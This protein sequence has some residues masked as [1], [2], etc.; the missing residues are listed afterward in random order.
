MKIVLLMG[1]FQSLTTVKLK[2]QAEFGKQTPNLNCIKDV[3]QRFTETG[4]VED[5]KRSGRP[6]VITEE[7]VEEVRDV[8][9]AERRQNVRTVAAVCAIPKDTVHRT[10][11][12]HLLLQPYKGHFVQQLYEEAFQDRVDMCE[13]LEPMLLN[14]HNEENF[15]FSDEAAFH[16]NVLINK[17]NVRYWYETNPNI[18]PE[19]V[20]KSP[21]VN[22]VQQ[23]VNR[24]EDDTVDGPKYRFHVSRIFHSRSEKE[25]KDAL[26]RISAG[27]SSSSFCS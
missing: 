5:R 20:M 6:S 25:E 13:T 16:L 7:I 12:E 18:Q 23:A 8:C 27:Q 9:E 26:F 15:F 21:K 10:M 4:T 17:H 14:D 3:F 1:K 22:D 19:T 11:R 24:F 2:L